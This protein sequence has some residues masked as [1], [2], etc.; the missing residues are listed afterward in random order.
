MSIELPEAEF[1]VLIGHALED[2]SPDATFIR[3]AID[4]EIFRIAWQLRQFLSSE[5]DLSKWL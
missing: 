2:S 3:V 1:P 4:P 5:V